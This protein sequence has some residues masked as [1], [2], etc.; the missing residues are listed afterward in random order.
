RPRTPKM[1]RVSSPPRIVAMSQPAAPMPAPAKKPEWA[2]RMWEG[3][4][5]F[6]WIKLLFRNRFAVHPRHWYIAIIITFVSFTNTLLRLLQDA[7]LGRAIRAAKIKEPPIFILGHWRTGTT[8]L[9]ELM[10]CDE[11]FGYPTT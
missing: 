8:L 4:D 10:I 11:R 9:H 2:P 5:F 7:L 1:Y 3:C 6:A